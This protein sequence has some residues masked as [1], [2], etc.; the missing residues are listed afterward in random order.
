[1][2]KIIG[3]HFNIP[4]PVS[5]II[6]KTIKRV[7]ISYPSNYEYAPH[8]TVYLCRFPAEKF[9]K[10]I[11]RIKALK[12][13]PIS[14][15]V[16]RVRAQ[17][18][19]DNQAFISLTFAKTEQIKKLQRH[20]FQTA[21]NLRSGLIRSKDQGLLKQGVLSEKERLYLTK[22]GSYRILS[23]YSPHITLG[24]APWHQATL[25]VKKCEQSLRLLRGFPLTL[26]TLVVGLYKYDNTKGK[27][28]KVIREEKI[29]LNT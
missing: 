27:Y 3:I 10:L 7:V 25:T 28:T 5:G 24:K 1:M 21:N 22:Y 17:R 13:Q 20:I 26:S 15:K 23:L 12:S 2:E 16:S 14:L 6:S 29:A 18:D 4:K 11:G 8:I 19:I 9:S